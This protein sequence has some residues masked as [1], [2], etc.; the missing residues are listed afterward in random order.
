MLSP[1]G[2]RRVGAGVI[3]LMIALFALVLIQAA[4]KWGEAGLMAALLGLGTWSF[5]MDRLVRRADRATNS[6]GAT[7]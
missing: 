3:T 6:D 2:G 4:V 7:R 1:R 5:G